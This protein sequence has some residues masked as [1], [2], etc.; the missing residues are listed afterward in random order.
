MVLYYIAYGLLLIG[1]AVCMVPS[2]Q[3]RMVFQKS[4]VPALLVSLCFFAGARSAGVDRDYVNYLA[5]FDLIHQNPLSLMDWIKDPAFVLASVCA[6]WLSVGY[7]A[8]VFLFVATAV[9]VKVGFALET[10]YGRWFTL[11]LYLEFCKF[12]LSQEMTQMRAAVSVPLMS[13]AI[14]LA[15]RGNKRKIAIGIYV[16]ALL[17]HFAALAG[18][19]VLLLLLFGVRFRSVYWV[20]SLVPFSIALSA[21]FHG[22][23]IAMVPYDRVSPYLNG[24]VDT[25]VINFLSVFLLARIAAILIAVCAFWRELSFEERT[26]VFCCA[27]GVSFQFALASNDNLSLRFAELFGLF[28]ILV[29]ILPLRHI[30]GNYVSFASAYL[31]LLFGLGGALFASSLKIVQ[32]YSAIYRAY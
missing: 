31:I 13:L 21:T 22:S 1:A 5:W 8:V 17:F 32:P 27:L 10:C 19:P 28:D 3:W 4:F 29:L 26:I 2:T 25:G 18:L 15:G 7:V 24:D 16:V 30:K 11:F 12:F 20:L 23:L 14:V 9:A 6:S